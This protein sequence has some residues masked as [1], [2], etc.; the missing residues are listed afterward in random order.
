MLPL[1]YF[2][3]FKR[4]FKSSGGPYFY[5]KYHIVISMANI[6]GSKSQHHYLSNL[7]N[8]RADISKLTNITKS[9]KLNSKA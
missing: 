5:E 3:G 6:N 2:I 7:C 9:I 8:R 1:Q 4:L